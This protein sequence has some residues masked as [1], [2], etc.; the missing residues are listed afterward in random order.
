MAKAKANPQRRGKRG[1][2][3]G[4]H[5]SPATEF[6]A[7]LSGNP[8][9]MTKEVAAA[10]DRARAI[11]ARAAPRIMRAVLKLA[12]AAGKDDGVRLAAARE[13]LDRALG[14]ASQPIDAR[15]TDEHRWLIR[16]PPLEPDA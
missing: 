15:V 3:P 12:E 4:S 2:K 9:G 14:R 6:K 5:V 10:R 11:A 13:I 16:L 7:G 8:G 1:P